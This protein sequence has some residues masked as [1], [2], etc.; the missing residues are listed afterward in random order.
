VVDW[1]F[2]GDMMIVSGVG[3]MVR[4]EI[5]EMTRLKYLAHQD[6]TQAK[7]RWNKYVL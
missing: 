6:E 2:L 4:I 1:K 3:M 5:V 7:R